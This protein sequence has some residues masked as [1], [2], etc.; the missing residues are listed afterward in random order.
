MKPTD[1]FVAGR[2]GDRREAIRSNGDVQE[3]LK[4]RAKEAVGEDEVASYGLEE[5]ARKRI[6]ADHRSLQKTFNNAGRI[7][8]DSGLGIFQ[9]T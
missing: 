5:R 8:A 9:D 6:V 4:G 2:V 3:Q 7:I 1:P